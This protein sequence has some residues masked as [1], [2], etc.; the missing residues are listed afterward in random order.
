M[1]GA[2]DQLDAL[3][4]AFDAGA[5]LRTE[6]SGVCILVFDGGVTQ[7]N[8]LADEGD[9]SVVLWSPVGAVPEGSRAQAYRRMLVAN[10]FWRE[11]DGGTLGLEPEHEQVVLALRRPLASLD[12][13][14]LRHAVELLVERAEAL[15]AELAIVPDGGRAGMPAG[16]AAHLI[17]RG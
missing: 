10:L 15:R 5:G 3:L 12:V 4:A 7:V 9:G 14:G 6:E 17:I 1:T 2:R 16:S 13:D 11:T 8:L